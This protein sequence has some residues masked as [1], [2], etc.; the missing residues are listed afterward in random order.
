[1]D[2][3]QAGNETKVTEF[4]KQTKGKDK[5]ISEKKSKCHS[6]QRRIDQNKKLRKIEEIQENNQKE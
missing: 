1:M 4:R 5:F 3:K 6:T 2:T